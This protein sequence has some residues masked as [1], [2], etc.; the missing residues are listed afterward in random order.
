VGASDLIALGAMHALR[1]C[2]ISVPADVAV[3]GFDDI[4]AAEL[5][6]PPLT[7]MAQNTRLAGEILVETLVRRIRDEPAA[8]RVLP[9]RLVV[10]RSCGARAH[11]PSLTWDRGAQP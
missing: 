5:A 9:A 11:E 2:R 7:T 8:A 1:D 4:P 10:R 3:V 6:N